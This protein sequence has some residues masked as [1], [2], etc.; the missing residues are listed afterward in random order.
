MNSLGR[1]CMKYVVVSFF[2]AVGYYPKF[3]GNLLDV[4]EYL[5]ILET[6]DDVYIIGVYKL[7]EWRVMREQLFDNNTGD[8]S[9][10]NGTKR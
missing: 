3:F 1:Y 7:V 2:A 9:G 5:E 4:R 8:G 10:R 6:M